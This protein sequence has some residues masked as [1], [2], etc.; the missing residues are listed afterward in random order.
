MF[1]YFHI[2]VITF[3]CAELLILKLCFEAVLFVW[4]V[5]WNRHQPLHW[6]D[7]VSIETVSWQNLKWFWAVEFFKQSCQSKLFLNCSKSGKNLIKKICKKSWSGAH[8]FSLWQL[9]NG[10]LAPQ[11]F[12]LG[13]AAKC[14][15]ALHLYLYLY[16]SCWYIGFF[17]ICISNLHLRLYL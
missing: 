6:G 7:Q 17:H 15:C 16:F 12:G 8:C 13:G 9:E 5:Q 1:I 11:D 14:I 3:V 2:F 4:N 10:A